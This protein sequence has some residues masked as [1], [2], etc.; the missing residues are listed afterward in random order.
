MCNDAEQHIAWKAYCEAMQAIAWEIP[1]VQ[2]EIDLPPRDH[3]RIRDLGAVIRAN[4]DR[5]ELTPMRFGFPAARPG[6]SPVFNFRS[7]GRSFK[8]SRRCLIP[9]SAFFEFTGAKSPKT[10]HR[11]ISKTDPFLCIAGLWRPAE[12]N[13]PPDFTMLTTEPGPDVAPY[14]GRQIVVL[15]REDWRSWIYLTKPEAELLRP[16]PAGRFAVETTAPAGPSG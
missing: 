3:V 15:A 7:E 12:G 1:T 11:F 2:S 14:H 6:A 13:Q 9:V 10:L 5:A 16:S 8:D 4:G